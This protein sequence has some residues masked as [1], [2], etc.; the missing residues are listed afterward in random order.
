MSMFCERTGRAGI[1]GT[2]MLIERVVW[3][4]PKLEKVVQKER[5]EL[6][7]ESSGQDECLCKQ[8][9]APDSRDLLLRRSVRAYLLV[10]L[11]STSEGW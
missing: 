9:K 6:D 8:K 11:D 7:K 10:M 4:W 1:V 5:N 3:W 2:T